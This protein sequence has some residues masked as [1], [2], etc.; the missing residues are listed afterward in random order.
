MSEIASH[1]TVTRSAVSQHLLLLADVGLVE[2]TKEGRRRIYRVRPAG[3]RRL[4]TEIDKFWTDEL[5]VLVAES[6]ALR[7]NR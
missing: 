7:S 6:Q 5:D 1:F 2:A 4:Q 3:L